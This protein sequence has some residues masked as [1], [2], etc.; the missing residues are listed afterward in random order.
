MRPAGPAGGVDGGRQRH[1][2]IFLPIGPGWDFLLLLASAVIR[3][4][5]RVAA[6]AGAVV[7]NHLVPVLLGAVHHIEYAIFQAVGIIEPGLFQLLDVPDLPEGL[8]PASQ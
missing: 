4:H 2:S 5:D 3:D 6:A 1:L 7:L 8:Q